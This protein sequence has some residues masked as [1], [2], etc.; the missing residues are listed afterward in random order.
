MVSLA[1]REPRAYL[2]IHPDIVMQGQGWRRK[3]PARNG[4]A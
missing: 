3:G 4:I 2:A 1:F